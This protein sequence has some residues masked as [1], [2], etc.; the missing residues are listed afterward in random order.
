M[1]SRSKRQLSLGRYPHKIILALFDDAMVTGIVITWANQKL[2]MFSYDI[3]ET[4]VRALVEILL[5]L[6]VKKWLVYFRA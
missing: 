5:F 4:K 1:H 6:D 2:K 3:N